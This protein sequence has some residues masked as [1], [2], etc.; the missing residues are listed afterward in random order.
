VIDIILFAGRILLVALLY[1]FL[2]FAVKAG[3]GLVR[4]GAKGKK[5]TQLSSVNDVSPVENV[6][7]LTS[8][9]SGFSYN[10]SFSSRVVHNL[11]TFTAF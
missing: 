7:V 5:G 6:W 10:V 3:I 9:L 2:L 8:Q 1:I 4:G 11:E